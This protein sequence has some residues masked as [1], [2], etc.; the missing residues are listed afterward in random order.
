MA[1]RCE[2]AGAAVQA[3]A[4]KAATS[5]RVGD[6]TQPTGDA[7]S[8]RVARTMCEADA[9]RET[10]DANDR[11]TWQLVKLERSALALPVET[12]ANWDGLADA[13]IVARRLVE[14][15]AAKALAAMRAAA[16]DSDWK[17]VDRLLEEASAQFAGHAWEASVLAAMKR[18]AYGREREKMSREALYTSSWT[19]RWLAAASESMHSSVADA[20]ALPSFLRRNS[21][22][23]KKQ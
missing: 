13:E 14:L 9:T 16:N 7:S 4:L 22:Q 17:L 11:P 1:R 21:E 15:A 6:R 10:G 20:K 3:G 23:R 12:P 8:L 5:R 19:S 18:L 2:P